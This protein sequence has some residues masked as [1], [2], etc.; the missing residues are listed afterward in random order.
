VKGNDK[1]RLRLKQLSLLIF[2]YALIYEAKRFQWLLKGY[3]LSSCPSRPGK[4]IDRFLASVIAVSPREM[5]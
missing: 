5:P 3:G 2:H 1:T 4:S